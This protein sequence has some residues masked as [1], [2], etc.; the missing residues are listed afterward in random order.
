MRVLVTG[1]GGLLGSAV[2]EAARSRGHDVLAGV[3][4]SGSPGPRPEWSVELDVTDPETVRRVVGDVAPDAVVHCAAFTDVE[5]AEA[6]P[7]DAMAVNLDGTRTVAMTA[8]EAGSFVLYPSSANVFDGTKEGPYLP[9]DPTEPLNAYGRSKVA[10]EEAVRKASRRWLVVRSSWLYG[11]GGPNFVDGI[12]ERAWTEEVVEVAGDEWS[13]PTW[14]GSLAR[15]LVELLELELDGPPDRGADDDFGP[16]AEE[17]AR[18]PTGEAGRIVHLADRGR[19]SRYE[20][21]REAYRLEGI[22]TPLV[23]IGRED[24]ERAARPPRNTVLD[25]SRSEE[26]LGRTMPQWKE[27]LRRYLEGRS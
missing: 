23:E 19:A 2:T 16:S 14:T 6:R 9:E 7:H 21:A 17:R 10:G 18:P 25:L 1:A 15:A 12:L 22:S 3:R 4:P 11:A 26:R 20:L 24:V 27:S 5:A 8:E 13:R